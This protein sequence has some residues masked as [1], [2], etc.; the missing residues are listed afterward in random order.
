MVKNGRKAYKN[1]DSYKTRKTKIIWTNELIEEFL[2]LVEVRENIL[3]IS[4]LY[5][6]LA[7]QLHRILFL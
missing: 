6:V 3:N 2:Q 7:P 5:V 4:V 1:Q